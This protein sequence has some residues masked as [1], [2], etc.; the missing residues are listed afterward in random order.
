MVTD[1]R[2][3]ESTVC[4]NRLTYACG[5]G[6]LEQPSNPQVPSRVGVTRVGFRLIA[7]AAVTAAGG[8]LLAGC[9]ATKATVLSGFS[10][11]QEAMANAHLREPEAQMANGAFSNADSGLRVDLG[12]YAK[13]WELTGDSNTEF[14]QQFQVSNTKDPG[15]LPR[16]VLAF[17]GGLKTPGD[18]VRQYGSVSLCSGE[19]LVSIEAQATTGVKVTTSS[20]SF[21][22]T[23][24]ANEKKLPIGI[25]V[26]PALQA[27]PSTSIVPAG[28]VVQAQPTPLPTVG[29]P[30]TLELAPPASTI[31]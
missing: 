27:C 1:E 25:L 2:I 30:S 5:M 10:V 16:A 19:V 28:S 6:M 14:L 21:T 31:L 17:F 23:T 3:V 9:A 15:T 13:G 11:Q 7:F 8:V 26:E 4:R 22:V 20:R 18:E 29:V 12:P 24:A